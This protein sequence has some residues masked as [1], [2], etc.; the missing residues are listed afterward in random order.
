MKQLVILGSGTAGTMMANKLRHKLDKDWHITIVDQDHLHVYQPGLLFIPFGMYTRR[1]VL[2]P[3]R[4]FLPNGVELVLSEI[5]EV[6]AK[7]NRV[8]L[9]NGRLL[10]YDYLI[11][12]SGCN[13]RPQETEGMLGEAWKKNIF[14]FYTLDGSLALAQKLKRWE[15]GKLVVN[16]TEMPIKCPVAPLEFAFLADWFFTERGMRHKVEIEYVTPLPDAFTKPVAA[17]TLGNFLEKK[18]IGMH[19][20]FNT[21]N[22]D[23]AGKLVS[24]DERKVDF[25]LLVTVPTNMGADFIERSGMGDDLNFVPTDPHTLQAKY[26]DNVFVL[27][28]ATDLPTSKAGSVAHFQAEVL[29]ENFM[30]MIAG[31]ELLEDFDGHANCFVESGFG[32]G[33][34]IDFNYDV[35]PLPGKFP[36]PM[37]G[38]MSLLKESRI[39]HWGKLMFRWVYWNMLLKGRKLPVPHKMSMAGKYEPVVNGSIS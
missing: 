4:H 3:R 21:G 5:S 25:D 33:L 32:K 16:I 36:F 14:D 11:I 37:I 7:K 18:H 27:G 8:V 17:A 26:H 22:I 31:R 9:S 12:A 6:E 39:N 23:P 35:Q 20:E 28:D 38:P 30:R 29:T 2:R 34:L 19:R 13:I 10:Y 24:W 15:G 1:H